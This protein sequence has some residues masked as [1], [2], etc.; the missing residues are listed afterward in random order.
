MVELQP[1]KL[2]MPV[3]SRSPAP[4]I[5]FEKPTISYIFFDHRLPTLTAVGVSYMPKLCPIMPKL[6][7]H[8]I[9]TKRPLENWAMSKWQ[10]VREGLSRKTDVNYLRLANLSLA[11][12]S[13]KHQAGKTPWWIW[14][15]GLASIS[16]FPGF[17]LIF[18]RSFVVEGWVLVSVTLVYVAIRTWRLKVRTRSHSPRN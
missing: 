11:V 18:E 16:F 10:C 9:A 17:V 5:L 6:C 2:A 4:K 7:P 8:Q 1:S 14:L 3:R 12:V 15:Q 13:G